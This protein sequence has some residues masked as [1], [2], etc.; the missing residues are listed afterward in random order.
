MKAK[1]SLVQRLKN[2]YQFVKHEFDNLLPSFLLGTLALHSGVEV[3]HKFIIPDSTYA[4]DIH[5]NSLV[6]II[7]G[8]A[9]LCIYA[10]AKKDY[11]RKQEELKQRRKLVSVLEHKINNSDSYDYLHG[12]YSNLGKGKLSKLDVKELLKL[13]SYK[14]RN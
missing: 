8:I 5:M 9:S 10:K 14:Y 2:E 11:A 12:L 13:A 1:P 4:G 7:S 6:G 3:L